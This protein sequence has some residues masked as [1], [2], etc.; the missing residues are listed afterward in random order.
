MDSVPRPHKIPLNPLFF[1][2]NQHHND[3]TSACSGSGGKLQEGKHK[4]FGGTSLVLV[5]L[6]E[7]R[8]LCGA[9]IPPFPGHLWV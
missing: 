1:F 6:G 7:L 8:A 9:L 5:E 3:G 2:F 4:E